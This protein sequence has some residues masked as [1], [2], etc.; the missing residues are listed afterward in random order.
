MLAVAP[1]RI[2]NNYWNDCRGWVVIVDHG[3]YKT[4][5][6]HL[7]NRCPLSEGTAVS[8]GQQI[9]IVGNSPQ[10]N[11]L[12]SS[13]HLHFELLVNGVQVDPLPYLKGVVE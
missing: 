8:A 11:R 9:G 5:S 2:S 13:A 1:G 3:D 12:D 4:L 7:K 10:K 6:Q